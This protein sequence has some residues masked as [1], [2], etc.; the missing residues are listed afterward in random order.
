MVIKKRF[1]PAIQALHQCIAT[2]TMPRNYILQ[3]WM[4]QCWILQ[5]INPIC[6]PI[7]WSP[8][9]SA[10]LCSHVV[11][12]KQ[13]S[14]GSRQK[15]TDQSILW[16]AKRIHVLSWKTYHLNAWKQE[17]VLE[18]LVSISDLAIR[19]CIHDHS[20]EIWRG[21][22]P[23][24]PL[25]LLH[26]LKGEVM[27][28]QRDGPLVSWHSHLDHARK[29]LWVNCEF[30][31]WWSFPIQLA[32]HSDIFTFVYRISLAPNPSPDLL[33]SAEHKTNV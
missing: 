17:L 28:K 9:R 8:V 22:K 23:C 20:R 1:L 27:E 15:K 4:L 5:G 24:F 14:A 19:Y 33:K 21:K 29:C 11:T 25:E 3:Y 31:A 26:L 7:P 13:T 30:L 18:T 32:L 16:V 2:S 6:L 10:E 12:A